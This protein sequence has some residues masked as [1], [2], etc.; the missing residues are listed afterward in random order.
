[1]MKGKFVSIT[2][3]QQFTILLSKVKCDL[4]K[5]NT[6]F[7]EAVTLKQKLAVCLRLLKYYCINRNKNSF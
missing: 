7:R 3:T 5:Q 2:T 4:A 1:M 6:A